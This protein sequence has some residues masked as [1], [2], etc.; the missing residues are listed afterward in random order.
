M[1][2]R[3]ALIGCGNIGSLLSEDPLQ[4]G[5]INTHAEAYLRCPQ[6]ELVAV[7]DTDPLRLERCAERWKAPA[8]YGE[9][10]AMLR[11]EK[12][13]I[14]SI[15]TPDETHAA[16]LRDVLQDESGVKAVLCEKPFATSLAEAQELARRAADKKVLLAVNYSRRYAPNLRKLKTLLQSGELGEVQAISGWYTKGVLHNGS[17]WFDLIRMLAG[18]ATEVRAWNSLGEASGDPTLDVRVDLSS[19]AVA[20]LRGAD[21]RNFTIFE[22]DLVTRR[23]RVRLVD[24]ACRVELFRAAPSTSF[25]DHVELHQEACDFGEFRNPLLLAVQDLVN[26]LHTGRAPACTAEDGVAAMRISLA[27]IES[28]RTGAQVALEPWT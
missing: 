21:A 20:T 1:P 8:R 2:Y 3:A 28:A 7:C 10:R 19:G 4:Q 22:M 15:C 9:A 11:E 24:G 6:T 23:A 26:A 16:V 5:N 12:P 13:E 17:H 27:A 18:E 25:S 14:V